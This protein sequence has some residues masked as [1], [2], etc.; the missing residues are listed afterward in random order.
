MRL[1]FWLRVVDVFA[2]IERLSHRAW[3]WSV[4]KAADATDWEPVE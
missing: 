1:H 3:L 4:T 2:A